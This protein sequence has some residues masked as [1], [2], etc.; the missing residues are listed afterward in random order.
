MNFTIRQAQLT[1]LPYIYHICLST[2]NS[3]TDASALL[4]DAFIVGQYFAAPYLIHEIET[5]FVLEMNSIPVGYIL[6]AA[7]TENF[8][9][10]MN[11]SWLPQIRKYY[12]PT[13]APKSDLEKF[14]I[15]IINT[16]CH[17]PDFISVYPS[18]LHIDLLPVAQKQGFGK[19]MISTLM[20][21]LK[22]KG[23]IGLHLSVGEKNVNAIGFYKKLGFSEL[24]R[25]A[26]SVLMGIHLT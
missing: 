2:G 10:W 3:G 16:D 7:D 24:N 12:P 8:N 6:G 13:M 21:E 1:D 9:T 19:K 18:H 20:E 26:G 25:E 5:C 4:S 23:S 15:D 14:L 22:S 11:T 17:F